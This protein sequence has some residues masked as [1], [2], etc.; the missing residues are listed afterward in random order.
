MAE[1]KAGPKHG[2]SAR[3]IMG[4]VT[5]EQN[6]TEIK[7]ERHPSYF[8]AFAVVFRSGAEPEASSDASSS[9]K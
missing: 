7:D 8:L 4:E 3:Q 9:A 5:K 1:G 6:L 2:W